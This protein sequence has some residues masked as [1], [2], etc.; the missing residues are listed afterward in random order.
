[1][2]LGN[3]VSYLIVLDFVEVRF[4]NHMEIRIGTMEKGQCHS[5]KLQ[6]FL[7]T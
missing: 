2:F 7:T 5:F 3:S 6:M 1:M 4:H